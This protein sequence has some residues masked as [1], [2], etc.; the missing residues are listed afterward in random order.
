MS[1][2]CCIS[3]SGGAY[4]EPMQRC[5]DSRDIGVGQGE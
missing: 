1:V 4:A 2:L 3:K 5:L